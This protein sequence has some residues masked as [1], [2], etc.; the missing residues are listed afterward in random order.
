MKLLK[1]FEKFEDK[2]NKSLNKILSKLW[3]WFLS[4]IP[5]IIFDT[6]HKVKNTIITK[7]QEWHQ[8]TKLFILNSIKKAN[9][10]KDKLFKLIDKIQ[11]FPLKSKIFTLG[12]FIKELLLKTPLKTHVHKISEI[13]SSALH[14][15]F[16]FLEKNNNPQT[17]IATLALVMILFGTYNIYVSS[18][19]I[20]LQEFNTRAPASQQQYVDKPEYEQFPKRTLKVFNVKVPIFKESVSAIRSVTIDFTVRTDTRFAKQFLEEYEYKLKDYF[21]LTVEPVVS[22]FPLEEEGKSILKD[23][24]QRELNNFLKVHKVEGKVV[25]VKI[26]FIIA[27]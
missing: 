14:K 18:S 20:Y 24:I 21:F 2:T 7:S 9:E 8:K 15:F 25:E 27:S 4:L 23:K 17:Y 12:A 16:N 1:K 3:A 13:S 5:Q 22:E 26:I 10:L 6:Y 19:N 11:S